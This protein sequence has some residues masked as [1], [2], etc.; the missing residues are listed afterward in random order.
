[1]R[2]VQELDAIADA[3]VQ[4]HNSGTLLGPWRAVGSIPLPHATLVRLEERVLVARTKRNVQ[5]ALND[6]RE[7]IVQLTRKRDERRDSFVNG[8]KLAMQTPLGD[9]A[10]Q[11]TEALGKKGIGPR[12]AAQAIELVPPWQT[13]SVFSI[14]DSLTRIAGRN[15]NAGDRLLLD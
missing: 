9:D 1:M 5:D 8:I 3:V 13:Y 14:V 12:L 10:E 4:I 15:Q 7:A 6:V 2:H 11:V